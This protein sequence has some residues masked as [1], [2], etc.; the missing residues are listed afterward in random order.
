MS[1]PPLSGIDLKN[2][3]SKFNPILVSK[4]VWV[5]ICISSSLLLGQSL[6][7]ADLT[8]ERADR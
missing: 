8:Y 1:D 7:S 2:G 6:G 3:L 4:R 5:S